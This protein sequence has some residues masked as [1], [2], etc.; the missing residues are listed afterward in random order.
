[1]LRTTEGF[2]SDTESTL[3]NHIETTHPSPFA[4]AVPPIQ[5]EAPPSPSSPSYTL[6]CRAA[7]T[8]ANPM[9]GPPS[10]TLVSGID[11]VTPQPLQANAAFPTDHQSEQKKQIVNVG[12]HTEATTHTVAKAAITTNAQPGAMICHSQPTPLSFEMPTEP[13]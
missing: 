5:N 3:T 7:E 4:E 9:D 11:L 12:A 1:M 10:G 6:L 2:D 8:T 13:T